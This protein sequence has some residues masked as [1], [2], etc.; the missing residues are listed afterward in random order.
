MREK[1]VN[2]QGWVVNGDVIISVFVQ[3]LPNLNS[4]RMS[5]YQ[6][7]A[8]IISFILAL[9]K[10]QCSWVCTLEPGWTQLSS[11]QYPATNCYKVTRGWDK[12]LLVMAMI[13]V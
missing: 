6:A 7:K 9:T 8:A 1:I 12:S 2:S 4:D 3:L 10:A 5:R 11:N 13:K